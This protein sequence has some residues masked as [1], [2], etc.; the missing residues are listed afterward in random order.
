MYTILMNLFKGNLNLSE[1]KPND[2]PLRRHYSKEF[3]KIKNQLEGLLN[4]DGK[5]LLE[6]LLDMDTSEAI[7]SDMDSF[8]Y[9]FRL[10]ALLMIEVFHDKDNLINDRG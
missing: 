10:A 5:E 3:G 2:F 9:G 8:I 4:D 1:H 7:F 6:E